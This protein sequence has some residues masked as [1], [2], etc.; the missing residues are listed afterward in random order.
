M[1][2]NSTIAVEA[3]TTLVI[4][5]EQPDEVARSLN[6]LNVL[7]EYELVQGDSRVQHDRYFDTPYGAL[8]N[9]GWALRLRQAGS[10]WWITLKGP[11][12]RTDYGAMERREIEAIWSPESLRE[13][14]RELEALGVTLRG[15]QA[16][17][18]VPVEA[19]TECG[20]EVFHQRVTRR[21]ARDVRRTGRKD[22]VAE[23]VVDRVTYDLS[24]IEIVHYELEI[25]SKH[26]TY[27]SSAV[28]RI[29][30]ELL[31]RFPG[32]LRPW[33]LG[34]L[35]TARVI[36]KLLGRGGLD[37]MINKDRTLRPEAYHTIE[38]FFS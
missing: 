9:R 23:L 17:T 29:A 34:K 8:G 28:Q 15:R 26:K 21:H 5:S 12:R 16:D 38:R 6:R 10:S 22:I 20:L 31:E 25:E 14:L 4:C 33:S 3:E 30:V 11:A 1:N 32:D 36:E 35:A 37:G 18:D 19:M 2:K 7:G 13:I 24:G 27:G